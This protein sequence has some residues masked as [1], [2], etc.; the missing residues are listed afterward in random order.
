MSKNTTKKTTAKLSENRL[1]KTSGGT[2]VILREEEGMLQGI[3]EHSNNANNLPHNPN[4]CDEP[5]AMLRE[6][7]CPSISRRAL[8]E[9][10]LLEEQR[11]RR[12][13]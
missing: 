2:V 5:R 10:R 4:S 12:R 9:R 6:R 8:K 13:K 7:A 3:R 1:N 11:R